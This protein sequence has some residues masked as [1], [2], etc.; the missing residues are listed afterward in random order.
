MQDAA[1]AVI[2][3]LVE[4]IDAAE[5]LDLLDGAIP[6]MDAA[7]E[8][9]AR[10]E[11]LGDAED[12]EALAAVE[13]ERLAR[14]AVLELQRHDAHPDEIGAVDALEALGDDRLDA[15][16]EHA[17]GGPV[18]GGAGAVFLAGDDDE[19]NPLF[20]IEHR[21]VKIGITLPSGR[22]LVIPPSTP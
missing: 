12:V 8:L 4:G 15:E 14:C 13:L 5:E 21:R 20:L 6:A 19:R 3:E 1:V 10:L 22:C 11:A 18:T 7:G 9:A 17:F 16:E 2:F